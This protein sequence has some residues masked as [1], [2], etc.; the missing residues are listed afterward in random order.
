MLVNWDVILTGGVARGTG[1]VGVSFGLRNPWLLL[2]SWQ[3][4][5]LHNVIRRASQRRE[6]HKCGN[7]N[8]RNES[9]SKPSLPQAPLEKERYIY[10]YQKKPSEALHM[11]LCKRTT[12]MSVTLESNVITHIQYLEG[13]EFWGEI[14]GLSGTTLH[15]DTKVTKLISSLLGLWIQSILKQCKETFRWSPSLFNTL[16][17]TIFLAL[18]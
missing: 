18:R 7:G 5:R 4:N 1:T 11:E 17:I 6:L 9:C 2:W 3:C 15:K 12:L 16:A 14:G 10:S 13:L 8:N